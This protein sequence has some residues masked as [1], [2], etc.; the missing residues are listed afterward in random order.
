MDS[1]KSG[2]SGE[3]EKGTIGVEDGVGEHEGDFL[4]LTVGTV[5]RC[6]F[7]SQKEAI[8]AEEVCKFL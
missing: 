2:F 3:K 5:L 6:C 7:K 4:Y 1:V 8:R